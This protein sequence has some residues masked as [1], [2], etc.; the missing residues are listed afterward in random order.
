MGARRSAE[1]PVQIRRHEAIIENQ[2]Y[3]EGPV[4]ALVLNGQLPTMVFSKTLDAFFARHHLRI[5]SQPGTWDGQ[6]IFSS[7]AT[8]D[9]GIGIN[10][11]TKSMIH[12]IDEHIDEERNKVVDDLW[13]TSCVDGVSYIN[14]P[15]VPRGAKNATGDTLIT[16]GRIR[17]CV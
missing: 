11:T 17:C 13:R 3:K 10:K 14:R 9:S 7:T 12:L 2:G 8:H 16:D 6:P 4:S 1:Y 5:H 15:W